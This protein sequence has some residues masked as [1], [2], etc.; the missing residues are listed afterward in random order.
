MQQWPPGGPDVA[1][2]DSVRTELN[3]KTPSLRPLE[4]QVD[5]PA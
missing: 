5:C 2:M 1:S 3:Q 4:D